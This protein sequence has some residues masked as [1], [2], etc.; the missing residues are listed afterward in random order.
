MDGTLGQSVVEE[1]VDRI[2]RGGESTIVYLAGELDLLVS[3]GLQKTLE[4]EC[5]RSPRRLCLDLSAVDFLDSSALHVF[6]HT[7]KRL[8]GES[9]RLE[10]VGCTPAVRRLL[11]LTSLDRLLAT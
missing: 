1:V 8:A 6:V 4:T 2:D 5:D 3:P 9:A 11:S 7:H 10:L